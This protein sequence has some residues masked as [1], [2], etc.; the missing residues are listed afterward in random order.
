M[1]NA[2][3]FLE[4]RGLVAGVTVADAMLKAAHVQLIAQITTKPGLITLAVEGD[5]GACR[6]ALDAGRLAAG[7]LGVIVSEKVIGRPEPDLALFFKRPKAI[8][9]LAAIVKFLAD[10][11][12]G[13]RLDQI[14]SFVALPESEVLQHLDLAVVQG[15]LKKNQSRY[16]SA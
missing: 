3:G 14:A 6:A 1:H 9:P 13:K 12:Q 11:P 8:G 4:V 2:Y 10:F 15:L 5:I 16:L 7:L